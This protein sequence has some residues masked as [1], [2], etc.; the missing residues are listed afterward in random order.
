M[1]WNGMME[2]FQRHAGTT[3]QAKFKLFKKSWHLYKELREDTHKK[4]VFLV[5]GPLRFYPPY[6]EGF[7]SN[8]SLKRILTFF[9]SNFWAKKTGFIEKKVVFCLVVGGVYPP[10]TLSSPTTKKTLFYVCLPL[11]YT[12]ALC[13][14]K[15]E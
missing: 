7:F 2:G 14:K 8:N 13:R 15:G 10:Y 9:F 12:K 3:G 4:V 11:Q 5:V 6:T 1:T